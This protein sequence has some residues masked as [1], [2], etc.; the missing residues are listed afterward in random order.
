M[1]HQL[2]FCIEKP[3]TLFGSASNSRF[4][5]VGA[6]CQQILEE[7]CDF[8]LLALEGLLLDFFFGR[9][10]GGSSGGR[11]LA[12][13]DILLKEFGVFFDGYFFFGDFFDWGYGYY[14]VVRFTD[15]NLD[16]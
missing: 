15:I 3:L 16:N 6:A 7:I 14:L 13:I 11:S 8:L 4:P 12:L 2:F 10:A 9:K 5:S 1:S